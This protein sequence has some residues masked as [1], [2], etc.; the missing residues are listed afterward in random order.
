MKSR[1]CDVKSECSASANASVYLLN[2]CSGRL[3]SQA[4]WLKGFMDKNDIGQIQK[5]LNEM[6]EFVNKLESRFGDDAKVA[7]FLQ[8][9][10]DLMEK[11]QVCAGAATRQK[12]I[13][14]LKSMCV[15]CVYLCGAWCNI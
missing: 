3:E 13:D 10:K 8:E 7:K 11:G 4:R 12:D 2:D 9:M 5:Y 14:E 6:P 15:I 1:V